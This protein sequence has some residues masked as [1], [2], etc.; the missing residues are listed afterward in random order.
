MG[1][2]PFACFPGQAV[3]FSGNNGYGYWHSF[4]LSKKKNHLPDTLTHAG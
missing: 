1:A 3:S 2:A 4:P